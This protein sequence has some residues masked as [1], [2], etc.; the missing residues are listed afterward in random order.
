[1]KIENKINH[2]TL[3]QE[4][5]LLVLLPYWT[6]LIPPMG[7]SC[8]K[9]F[10]QNHGYDVKTDDPNIIHE[11][12]KIYN[13]Y[14]DTLK[15][16]VPEKQRGN[17]FSTGH[18]VM[19]NHLMAYLN[20]KD[21]NEYMELTKTLIFKTFF[22]Q[23]DNQCVLE[24]NKIIADFYVRLEEY[25]LD[26]LTKEKPS[27]LGIS[28]HSCTLPASLFAFKLTRK[29]FPGIKTVMGGGIFCDFLAPGTSNFE[30]LLD[31]TR[32]YI[33][34][35]IIG[36]GEILFLKLLRGEFPGSQRVFTSNDINRETLALSTVGVPDF[37]DF[38][39]TLYP[40]LSAYTSRSCPFQCNFCSDSAM[41]GKYR[42]KSA[43]QVVNELTTLSRRHRYQLFMLSDLLLNPIMN[44]LANEFINSE[45]SIYWDGCLRADKDTCSIKNTQLWRRGGFYRAR[46]GLESGSPHILNLMGKKVTPNQ[47]KDAVSSI[48][49]A[50]IQ[51]T[52]LWIVGYPGETEEDFLQTLALIEE[53]K[54]E[55]YEAECRPFYYYPK[56]QVG[57]AQWEK[58]NLIIPLYPEEAEKMLIFQTWLLK[59]LPSREESYQRVNRFVDHCKRL[60]IPNIYSMHDSYEADKRWAKLHKNAVP[61]MLDFKKKDVYID[62]CKHFEENYLIENVVK[63]EGD[64]NF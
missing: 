42:K 48:A 38:D 36:E 5:I 47:I 10:L 54:D 37:T 13:T 2:S 44:E 35:I 24:L 20:Y 27:I 14:F 33:D 51:T 6:A 52:T 64:F 15:E 49:F 40:Y 30:L 12:K 18:D 32:D 8:L 34:N 3:G 26:L 60:D 1:M 61:A 53:L 63:D 59:D 23:A 17:F 56:G 9:T 22:C 43:K 55:I 11:F 41:W 25:F 46:L 31:T 45:L 39:L 4:K 57:S 19:Q 7:I 21:E 16:I 58:N 50:G 29:H 28:V 62:E